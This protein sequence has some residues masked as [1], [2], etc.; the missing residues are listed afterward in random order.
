MKIAIFIPYNSK[1][2]GGP[3]TFLNLASGIDRIEGNEVIFITQKESELSSLLRKQNIRVKILPFMGLMNNSKGQA[4]KFNFLKKIKLIIDILRY[5]IKLFSLLRNNNIDVFITR[6]IK[7]VIYTFLSVKLLRVR[8]IWDLGLEPRSLGVVKYLHLLGMIVSDKIISQTKGQINFIFSDYI[9]K[10]FS[11]KYKTIYPGLHI[12]NKEKL[13]SRCVNHRKLVNNSNDD[14]RLFSIGTI[15][16]RKN[17]LLV[18]KA[19]KNL[20][21]VTIKIYGSIEDRE[22]YCKLIQYIETNNLQDRVE[23][24][25]WV[26]D[27]SEELNEFDVFVLCSTNEGLPQSIREAMFGGYP[28]I[29]TNVGGVDEVISNGINGFILS[30]EKPL[31]SLIE[32]IE[33]FN[34]NRYKITEFGQSSRKIAKSIFSYEK[35]IASYNYAIK[36]TD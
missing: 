27:I 3:R 21:N 23:I 14:L 26:N 6:N 13:L 2:T 15:T 10:F 1:M 34:N 17:H 19:I 29:T 12:K 24:A 5:N 25:G 33:Y 28:I 32:A 30:K 4:E 9:I 22:Y 8:L 36:Y 35:W 16:E 11:H 7:N 20:H 18:L 31:Q